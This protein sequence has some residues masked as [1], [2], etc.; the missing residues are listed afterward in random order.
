MENTVVN[1]KFKKGDKFWLYKIGPYNEIEMFE[2]MILEQ[3]EL[4]NKPYY[5][6]WLVSTKDIHKY[7]ASGYWSNIISED[8]VSTDYQITYNKAKSYLINRLENKI[9]ELDF[10]GN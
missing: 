4:C 5:R 9:G 6:F 10:D 2:A 3:V 7:F 8:F 1:F